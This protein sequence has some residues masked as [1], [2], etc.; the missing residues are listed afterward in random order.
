MAGVTVVLTLI[1]I[2]YF[3]YKKIS[4]SSV[5]FHRSSPVRTDEEIIPGIPVV[6][7]TSTASVP[8]STI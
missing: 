4:L 6:A 3:Y 2:L 1:V 7:D 5:T 8:S